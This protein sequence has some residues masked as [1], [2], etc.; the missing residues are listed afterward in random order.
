MTPDQAS[1]GILSLAPRS[2]ISLQGPD[3]QRF[4]NGQLTNDIRVVSESRCIYA[5]VLNAKG[6]LDAVCHVRMVDDRYLLDAPAELGEALVTRLDRYLIAD[7]VELSPV[8]DTWHLAHLVGMHP[9]EL[10]PELPDTTRIAS[11]NRL[12]VDGHDLLSPAP[13][14]LAVPVLTPDQA[15]ALRI[16][17]GVPAWPSELAPGLLPPEAGLDATAISYDKGCYLGQE[18]ISRM[19]RAGKTNRHLVQFFVPAGTPA[20]STILADQSPAG[21]VTSV[22]PISCGEGRTKA[23]GYRRRKSEK[24]TT[25]RLATPDGRD[26]PGPATVLKRLTG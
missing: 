8:T 23:L 17:H 19:K 20:G 25:F 15:E 14:D 10:Q 12:G 18:V 4:L 6:Q 16:G 2:F 11:V 22:S 13:L 9:D 7:Q 3:A 26:L 5:A 21:T 24:I 1:P